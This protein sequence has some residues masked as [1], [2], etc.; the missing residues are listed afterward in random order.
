MLLGLAEH[1]AAVPAKIVPPGLRTSMLGQSPLGR[2]LMAGT[3]MGLPVR[4]WWPQTWEAAV[5]RKAQRWAVHRRLVFRKRG[6]LHA[7]PIDAPWP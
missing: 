6:G 3:P 5:G 7:S 4:A 2:R 1:C